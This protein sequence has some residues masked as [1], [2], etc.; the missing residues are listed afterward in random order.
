MLSRRAQ[1]GA[2]AAFW[3]FITLLTSLQIVWLSRMPG[4]TFNVV[5]AVALQSTLYLSWIPLTV[6]TWHLTR[7]WDFSGQAW[8]RVLAMHVA[9]ALA[10]AAA[11]S[12][13]LVVVGLPL[14]MPSRDW[15][16]ATVTQ[17]RGRLYLQLIIYAGVV[18]SGHA[19]VFYERWR[20][21]Q[22]AAAALERQLADA[23][24]MALHAQLHPHFLFNSL[25]AI[26]ALVRESRNAEAVR[27]IADLGTL[28]RRVL[29][30]DSVTVPLR[31]ELELART[32]LDVQ[33]ARFGD[34]LRW[35]VDVAPGLDEASV[36]VLMLQPLIDNALRH[37][38]APK[39]DAGSIEVTIGRQHGRLIARVTD[40]GVGVPE[41]WRL[42]TCSGTGLRN[43]SDR[44][45]AIYGDA[46]E[47]SA[48]PT[49]RGGF[50]ASVTMPME[51]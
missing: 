14:G 44:L 45:R 35:Q 47:L 12:V 13:L 36:P 25:H 34:R 23:R 40:D 1:W 17:F 42:D 30:A 4:E 43:L 27:L 31:T 28:L 16:T 39:V 20:D 19:I 2:A 22:A 49:P 41:Q 10:I 6:W 21:R 50:V 29:D 9:F 38:L 37:G 3:G 46:A 32:Y 33:S 5:R 26:A 18:A 7:R 51:T 48:G 24:V 11:Q 15:W 8:W